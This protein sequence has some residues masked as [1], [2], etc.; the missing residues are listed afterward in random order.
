MIE[1]KVH[2]NIDLTYFKFNQLSVYLGYMWENITTLIILVK[3]R[4]S[5]GSGTFLYTVQSLE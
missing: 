4:I 3:S 5:A 2:D 1:E